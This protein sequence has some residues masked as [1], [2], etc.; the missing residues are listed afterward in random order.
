MYWRG[1]Q[2]ERFGDVPVVCCVCLLAPVEML[3]ENKTQD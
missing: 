2:C 3:E 1:R